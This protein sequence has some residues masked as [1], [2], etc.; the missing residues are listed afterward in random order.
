MMAIDTLPEH[1]IVAGGS[2]IGLEFAQMYRRFGARVTVVE[3]GDRLIAR[4]DR[5]R[6][7]RSPGDPRARRHRL[8]LSMR[9]RRAST[10]RG[11]SGV[12]VAARR[13]RPA[14]G[15]RRQPPAAAVGRRPNTDDLGLDA[16]GIADRRARLHRRR[17]R[18]AH[19]RRRASGRSATPTAAAPSRTP[20]TTTTRSSPTTCSTATSAR[21]A[22]ASRRTRSSSTRRSAASA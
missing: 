14:Q 21:S 17:R 6:V 9:M 7:A 16:A 20:R 5:G 1:L 18:A 3:Y 15:R 19:Q 11:G 22:T 4:E 13:R 12:R 2:Y 10:G 8:P